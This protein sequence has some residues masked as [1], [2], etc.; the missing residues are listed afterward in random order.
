MSEQQPTSGRKY[1][2]IKE[3]SEDSG[4]SVTQ[5]RRWVAA[6]K[7]AFFQPGGKG[8]KLLFPPDALERCSL[9]N[10]LDYAGVEEKHLPGSR[11]KWTKD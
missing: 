1:L 4:F 3:L 11:P 10:P 9:E 8:G 5:I 2:T 7:I 6:E